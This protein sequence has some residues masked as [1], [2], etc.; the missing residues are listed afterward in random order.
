MSLVTLSNPLELDEVRRQ[1]TELEDVAFVEVDR[2]LQGEQLGYEG[3]ASATSLAQALVENN[4]NDPDLAKQ[5]GLGAID[6]AGAWRASKGSRDV[7][8]CVVDTGIDY[9]HPD[10]RGNMWEHGEIPGNGIDDDGNGYV[11]DV[12]GYDFHNRDSDPQ[13][14]HSH[15]THIAGIIGAIAGNGR[16]IVGVSHRVSLMA[17]KAMNDQLEGFL[18][19]SIR[20]VQYCFDNGAD[21]MTFSWGSYEFSLGLQSTLDA[22]EAAGRL[23]VAS[24]GNSMNDNDLR[25]Y[26]PA[27]YTHDNILVVASVGV[28]NVLSPWSSYGKTCVD[29]AAPG[30]SVYST[31]PG[32]SYGLKWGTSQVRIKLI[33]RIFAKMFARRL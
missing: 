20:C 10:L 19:D 14:D 30:E 1:V 17:C 32:N 24:A 4:L 3:S 16:G 5:W 15:G 2:V 25:P 28:Q 21:I 31:M 26:F 6:A 22:V 23:V 13:D 8:V 33:N 29:I 27:C 7:Q 11:D 9:T 18:S 12:H